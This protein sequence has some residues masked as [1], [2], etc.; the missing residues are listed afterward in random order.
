M[1]EHGLTQDGLARRLGVSRVTINELVQGKRPLTANMA[2]RLARL[3]SQSPGFWLNL[4][5]AVDVWDADNDQET[6]QSLAKI[7]PLSDTSS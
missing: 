1:E 3:T 6:L 7:E 5:R 4:Q 2:L